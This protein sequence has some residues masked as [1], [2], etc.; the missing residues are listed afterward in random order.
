MKRRLSSGF[1]LI[2]LLVVVSIIAILASMLLPAISLVRTSA[3]QVHC[4]NNLKQL[5]VLIQVYA[6]DWN[7]QLPPRRINSLDKKWADCIAADEFPTSELNEGTAGNPRRFAIF[8]CPE[9]KEQM[10][11]CSSN[12]GNAFNS[13]GPNSRSSLEDVPGDGRYFG[14]QL[15]RI[16]HASELLVLFDHESYGTE[17]WYEDGLSTIPFTPGSVR[18]VQ[19][20]HGRRANLL[21]A[22]GHTGSTGLLRGR[23]AWNLV[24]HS[25]TWA[26]DYANGRAWWATN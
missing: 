5:F 25:P 6:E 15:S 2:E 23:G 26:S 16:Q 13:Y 3:R 19:Y 9:N 14:A 1:T 22:D 24:N 17:P 12:P 21:F 20:R 4:A 7:G 18:G 10:W 8:N 11:E